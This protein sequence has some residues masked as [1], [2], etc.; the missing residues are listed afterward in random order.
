MGRSLRASPIAFGGAGVPSPNP[1]V[2]AI[3]L[4]TLSP[5]GHP[6]SLAFGASALPSRP[7]VSD[8]A[9]DGAAAPVASLASSSPENARRSHADPTSN[10]PSPPPRAALPLIVH[11]G[12]FWEVRHG[13]LRLQLTWRSFSSTSSSAA[14]RWRRRA[15]HPGT[16]G[17]FY[18]A[19]SLS[20]M[21]TRP[22]TDSDGG[23]S[24]GGSSDD[25][26]AVVLAEEGDEG[27]AGSG[28]AKTWLVMEKALAQLPNQGDAAMG[29]GGGD[30]SGDDGGDGAAGNDGRSLDGVVSF[31]EE[32]Y[33]NGRVVGS[34]TGD[35]RL[36][37]VP[38]LEQLHHGIRY[39]DR[40]DD[41]R[42]CP[43]PLAS[44]QLSPCVLSLISGTLTEGGIAF[45]GPLVI[46]SD[47]GS[48]ANGRSTDA[49]DRG[50][51]G[52]AVGGSGSGV[53]RLEP[54]LMAMSRSLRRG[55]EGAR[56]VAA[57]ELHALLRSSHKDSLVSFVFRDVTSLY[58][59]RDLMLELWE[60]LLCGLESRVL[61]FAVS[62]ATWP[63][64]LNC[65]RQ[66]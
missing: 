65:S 57:L 5:N 1:Q 34:V 61:G 59:C 33:H 15:K 31:S 29:D 54:L 8:V 26:A 10:A 30:G 17:E 20:K 66:C 3:S 48:A 12:A 4:G 43:A 22:R 52:A 27:A 40:T 24:S 58:A 28:S 49:L 55:D 21:P 11:S 44:L 50:D 46:G 60:E 39:D 37:D 45:T 41:G 42:S 7:E 9:P 2:G 36:I 47:D 51:S 62:V 35:L 64:M 23:Q 18:P 19:A 56:Q 53:A 25:G 14:Q 32:L 63:P 13:A 6:T 16:S 38:T